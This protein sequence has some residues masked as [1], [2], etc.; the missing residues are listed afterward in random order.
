MVRT[1]RMRR[2]SDTV[3]SL[4]ASVG[5]KIK[6]PPLLAQ[7]DVQQMWRQFLRIRLVYQKIF[8]FAYNHVF[9]DHAIT[10]SARALAWASR[11]VCNDKHPPHARCG[12]CRSGSRDI[13]VPID[14]Q[15][16]HGLTRSL[17]YARAHF[18]HFHSYKYFFI[19]CFSSKKLCW[20]GG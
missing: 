9:S 15:M 3:F 10:L 13:Q 7:L 18:L 12:T 6:I 1:A 2:T 8:A 17:L 11:H 4:V 14:G 19:R 16:L 20:R 5:H